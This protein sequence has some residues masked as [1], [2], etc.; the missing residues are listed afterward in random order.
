MKVSLFLN[1]IYI[2]SWGRID[3]CFCLFSFVVCLFLLLVGTL[4]GQ[5]EKKSPETHIEKE[6]NFL[7]LFLTSKVKLL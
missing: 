5:E 1:R 3:R 2:A 4:S 6:S 7:A